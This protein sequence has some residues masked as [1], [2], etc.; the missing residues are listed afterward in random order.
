MQFFLKE[1][2]PLTSIILNC[3]G[4][5]RFN[6]QNNT[7]NIKLILSL[8]LKNYNDTLETLYVRLYNNREILDDMILRMILQCPRLN[9]FYFDG[10]TI[11]KN[12][13]LLRNIFQ[14]RNK[15]TI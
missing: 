6:E 5:T 3:T 2:I 1:H 10:I 11:A 15:G 4:K 9:R 13:Q 8:I 12:L 14:I 7:G